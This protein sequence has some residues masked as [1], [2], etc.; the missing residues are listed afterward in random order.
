VLL[1]CGVAVYACW[2]YT[3][4][5]QLQ[6]AQ[7]ELDRTDSGWRMEEIESNREPI[8][9]DQ[10]AALCVLAVG[11]SLPEA[12]SGRALEQVLQALDPPNQLN[13]PQT[14]LLRSELDR[15]P[16]ALAE[17]RRLADLP[18]GRYPVT[19]AP[20]PTVTPMEDVQQAGTV[21]RLLLGDVL[22]RAQQGDT[23]S[24]LIHEPNEAVPSSN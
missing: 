16:A 13:E 6:A 17:A 1:A 14:A 18:K 20:N 24:A 12:W 8:P 19:W 2:R 9:D 10:N 22:L 15:L 23:D 11:K 4:D 5:R 21:A 7:A 3:L